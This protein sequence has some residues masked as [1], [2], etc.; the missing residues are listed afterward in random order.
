[1]AHEFKI[2]NTSGTITTYT[3]Y[4]SIPTSDL[5][6][7]IKF[8]PDLGTKVDNNEM[9]LESGSTGFPGRIVPEDWATSSENHLVLETASD[10]NVDNHY[11][12]PMMEPHVSGDGHTEEEHREIE[13][14]GVKFDALITAGELNGG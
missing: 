4:D 1:M 12:E 6:Y 8:V 7:V 3:D 2:Q 10:T 13:L 11:H 5:K 9:Q 14:W